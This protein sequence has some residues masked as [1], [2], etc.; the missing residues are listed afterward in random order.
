MAKK[1]QT[2]RCPW[3][4]EMIPV[5]PNLDDPVLAVHPDL[6]QP[7]KQCE[8]SARLI[9]ALP[10]ADPSARGTFCIYIEGMVFAWEDGLTE[11][12][13]REYAKGFMQNGISS[14]VQDTGKFKKTRK[15]GCFY[16][17]T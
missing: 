11:K 14:R 6:D 16:I 5:L 4:N 10:P 9:R 8:G 2:C 13:A 1:W 7:K 17:S 3:C 15:A 12:S